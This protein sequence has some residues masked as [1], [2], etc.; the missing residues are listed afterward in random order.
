MSHCRLLTLLAVLCSLT[1]AASEVYYITANSSDLCTMQPCLTLTQFAANLSRYLHS[2]NTTLVF[3]P[4]TH[5]LS[6]VNLTLT[7][8]ENFTIK[9]ENS[10][11][12][13]KCTNDSSM[14]FSQSQSIHITDLE[15]IGCGGNQVIQVKEFLITDTMFKGQ[16]NVGTALKLIGTTAQIVNGIFVSNRKG[17]YRKSLVILGYGHGF[18]GGAIIATDNTTVTISQSKFEDNKA[19][20]GGA[21]FADNYTTINLT[22]NVSFINNSADSSGGALFSRSNTSVVTINASCRFS[23]N[24]GVLWAF[25]STLTIEAS[26][27]HDNIDSE[28]GVLYLENSSV[29]IEAS[30]FHDNSGHTG[31]VLYFFYCNII[32]KASEFHD[33][34]AITGGVLVSFLSNVVIERSIFYSNRASNIGG[35]LYSRSSTVMFGD[36]SFTDNSSPRGAVIFAEENNKIQYHNHLFI[37]KNLGSAP[38]YLSGSEFRGND[39]GNFIFTNNNGSLVAFNSNVTFSGYTKFMNNQ[40]PNMTTDSYCPRIRRRCN[41]SISEQCIY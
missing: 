17:S 10:T 32:I 40:S 25:T 13:I 22:D 16:E 18:V 2:D 24:K 20:V 35:E 5:H 34:A 7:N 36:C 29:T 6:N 9:S 21:I 30:E 11:A 37:D 39:S 31:S 27:F 8:V 38:I 1:L 41:N 14:H 28:L 26:E 4:G 33:N 3:L 19:D 15:F 23:N 12:Q